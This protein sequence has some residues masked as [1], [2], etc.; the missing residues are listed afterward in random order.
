[1]WRTAEN[2][3]AAERQAE[4]RQNASSICF[5]GRLITLKAIIGVGSAIDS[6]RQEQS[7]GM[8]GS[9]ARRWGQ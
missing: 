5:V 3:P 4:L 8:D 7:F 1:M 6:F 9:W 2:P